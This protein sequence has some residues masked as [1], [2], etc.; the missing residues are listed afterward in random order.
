MILPDEGLC[1]LPALATD[2]DMTIDILTCAA[3]DLHARGIRQWC[4]PWNREEIR[5]AIERKIVF[6]CRLSS[7]LTGAV[8]FLSIESKNRPLYTRKEDCFYL[9]HLALLPEFQRL[10]IGKRI[11]E[12]IQQM[13]DKAARN[14]YL[15]CWQGNR[16][17]K[18]FYASAGFEP[19]AVMDEA[20]YQIQVFRYLANQRQKEQE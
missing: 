15:D 13:A 11:V 19:L 16:K 4:E 17:L 5:Q 7:G 6:L 1:F 10:G 3:Q 9:Y 20:D 18:M 14:I 8:F 12:S 2:Q